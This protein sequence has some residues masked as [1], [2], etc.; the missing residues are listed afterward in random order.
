METI[1]FDFL[2]RRSN[3]SVSR[4]RISKR[5]LHSGWW[6]RIFWL[7]QTIFLYIFQRLLLEK[8]F[9]LSS[10]NLFLSESLTAAIEERIFLSSGDH[11]FTWKFF[12]TSGNCHCYEWKPIFKDRTYSCRW[13]LIF[14]HFPPLSHI[15]FKESFIP[16][17]G[18]LYFSPEE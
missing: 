11:H 1:F 5:M 2:A 10:G 8:L 16:I 4:K 7:V 18:N 13:K 14:N 17:S 3:L 9:F 6:K 15:F 12:S